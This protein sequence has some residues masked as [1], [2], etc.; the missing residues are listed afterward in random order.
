VAGGG[1]TA[2]DAVRIALRLP[3]IEEV[4]LSYRRTREEMPADREELES[5]IEEGG[6]LMELSLPERAYSGPDGLRLAL[7][8]MELGERDASGRRS[9][10]PTDRTQSVDCEL[11]VAA[12]GESPD[13]DLLASLGLACGPKGTPFYDPE[14]QASPLPGVYIGGDTARGP[15][16]IISAVADGRRAAHA[17]LRAAG[18]EPPASNYTPSAPDDDK[19]STR[20]EFAESAPRESVS[21]V[22]REAERCLRCDSACL[23][24]VEV[25]PNRA[26]FALPVGTNRG[27]GQSIQILHVDALCNECGNCRTFCPFDDGEPYR[28]KPTL[29]KDRAAMEA[30]RGEATARV[31]NAGFCFVASGEDTRERGGT[32]LV[33][34]TP[35]ADVSELSFADWGAEGAG[36]HMESLAR[37]VFRH[38]RYL[39]GGLR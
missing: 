35:G 37:A 13:S 4:R 15:A 9:P 8:V 31:P 14:T 5:A 12:V 3:G 16:S 24:C 29:F 2:M 36:G 21:F 18:I 27:F 39:I 11:I 22:P 32:L 7:R 26:N 17:I 10:R 25:C 6:K 33:R 1:N 34:A 23:R 38:H 30:R 19:L 28:G 20:G